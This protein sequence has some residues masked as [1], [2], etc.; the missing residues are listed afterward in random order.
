LLTSHFKKIRCGPEFDTFAIK[1]F[2]KI[3]TAILVFIFYAAQSEAQIDSVK[4]KSDTLQGRSF[5]LQKVDRNGETLPEVEIKEVTVYAHPQ[6][7]K[8]SDFRKY[9]RLV[10]NLKRVYPYAVIVRNRLAKVNNDLKDFKTEKERKEYMRKEEK[11][12]FAQYEGDM[13]EM[14]ITQGRLLIKLIDRE[15]QNTS[16]ILIKDYRGKLAAA[17]W[18]GVARIF[19]TNLKE[20]YDPF[21]DDALIESIIQEIDAGRL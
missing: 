20:E 3:I 15:T 8:K 10:A 19:G 11:N 17:F 16:Y 21:G 14:T 13:R 5:L 2:V 12:V 9:E 4:Q 1:L 7:P 6:F 18:Q